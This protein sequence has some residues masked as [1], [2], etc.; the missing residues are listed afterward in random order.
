[1]KATGVVR[2]VDDLGRIVIPKEIRR[3]LRIRDGEDLEVFVENDII[4]LK[5]FSKIAELC[6]ISKKI[7]TIASSLIGK[8]ILVTDRDMFISGCGDLKKKYLNKKISKNLEKFICDANIVVQKNVDNILFSDVSDICS[9]VVNPIVSFGDVIGTVI[10][11]SS[12]SDISEFD[13]NIV[14]MI[15]Q[16]LGKYVED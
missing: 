8:T 11:L 1:M 16:F 15:A 3:N 7:I 5:K 9:Y 4:I 10:V 14:N 12:N 6:D 13:I 2:R